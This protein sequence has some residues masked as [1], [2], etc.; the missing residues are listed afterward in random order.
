MSRFVALLKM[1]IRLLF[2]NKGF[3]FFLCVMP[4]VST[5]ILLMQADYSIVKE[6]KSGIIDL[7]DCT[8][9]AV[10]VSDTSKFIIKVYD[11]SRTELSE[12][13]LNKL[14]SVGVFSVCRCDVSDMTEEEVTSQAKKDAFDDKA[15]T[16]LYIKE[17][18]DK[19]VIEGK[20]KDAVLVYTTSDDDRY[21]LFESDMV[22]ILTTIN[23]VGA[24]TEGDNKNIL[25][26]L[27]EMDS[28][29]PEK[30]VVSMGGVDEISLTQKQHSQKTNMGY[31]FA[32]ITLGFLFCGVCVAHTVI[33]EQNNKVY[34]R[35]MISKMSRQEYLVSKF[36]ITLMMSI[37]QT[38]IMGICLIFLKDIEFGMDKLSFLFII[39]CL[40]L[41][42]GT[43][44]FML[45]VVIGDVMSSN[46]AVFTL[47]SM[48]S[49]L[50]GL[51]FP[52]DD[53]TQ[54]LKT[55]SFLMPHRWF[56]NAAEMLITGNN[57]A[58]SLV[59][60]VTIAYLIITISL[61]G[62]GLKMKENEA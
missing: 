55:L 47:W 5:V 48:S 27:S 49:L 40:G 23:Q 50:S 24:I 34:T 25:S 9:R 42:F 22:S 31:A 4:I 45:G 58:Y 26:V 11:D 21:Q 57:G 12:Y 52:L 46:F 53:T 8:E 41:I 37:V 32:I 35:I 60:C 30:K 3:L 14:A 20:Y 17:D 54:A 28:S 61:G 6:E 15:G 13:L 39:F 10:Y 43:I 1:S 19:A 56:M 18:F 29:L 7:E 16:I 2:R 51:Y 59:I 36:M 33:E 38:I 62:I 44:S